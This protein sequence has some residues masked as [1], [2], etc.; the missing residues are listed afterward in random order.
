MHHKA[1]GSRNTPFFQTGHHAVAK[2]GIKK[3]PHC[4][5]TITQLR[6]PFQKFLATPLQMA[7]RE[8]F[9]GTR[10][11]QAKKSGRLATLI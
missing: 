2:D 9:P 4:F 5:E 3:S 7:S 10:D 1:F 11:K 8:M 6:T